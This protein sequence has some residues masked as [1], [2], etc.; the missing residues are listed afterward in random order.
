MIQEQVEQYYS[1][2]TIATEVL[3]YF[4]Q[5]DEIN[6]YYEYLTEQL[7]CANK[8]Q[9]YLSGMCTAY[10][11]IPLISLAAKLASVCE[12]ETK[13]D[14]LLASL[15]LT[16]QAIESGLLIAEFHKQWLVMF[17]YTMSDELHE[18]ISHRQYLPP[19]ID[20][21]NVLKRHGDSYF[22]TLRSKVL[23]GHSLSN[24]GQ[25]IAWDILNIQSSIPFEYES[26]VTRISDKTEHKEI[27]ENQYDNT[28]DIISDKEFY[29]THGYDGRGRLYCQGHH[30]NY[31]GDDYHK[32]VIVLANKEYL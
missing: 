19:M 8:A 14:K 28:L 9:V 6:E 16:M 11:G 30:I 26:R 17:D 12:G 22:T 13:T 23:T 10:D 7:G 29:L 32:A 2:Q 21:P 27:Y 5:V 18:S 31:Q 20:K 3:A 15:D 25:E 24:I 1:K 4:L